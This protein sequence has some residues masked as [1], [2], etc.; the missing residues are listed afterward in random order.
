MFRIIIIFISVISILFLGIYYL[1]Q[2]QTSP[3]LRASIPVTEAISY[4][5]TS[6]FKRAQKIR[7]FSFPEDHGPHPEFQSEWWYFT[8]NLDSEENQHFG[9]Q[10][11]FFRQTVSND[12]T[13]R[14]SGWASNEIY[15][16]HLALTDVS[17]KKFY[18][19]ERFS[20]S[21]SELAGSAS[22]P[23]L[24]SCTTSF[25]PPAADATTGR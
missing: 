6:G 5:D 23:V 4:G 8:G 15:M 16:G 14:E 9:F 13:T 1:D 11:T 10:L 7:D 2:N 24:P 19:Y 3:V 20:R 12:T 25:S 17:N 22:S 21:I 18:S